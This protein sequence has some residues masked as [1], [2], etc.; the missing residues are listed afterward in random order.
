MK[1]NNP[2]NNVCVLCN[3]VFPRHLPAA[4]GVPELLPVPGPSGLHHPRRGAAAGDH[5]VQL[6]PHGAGGQ[7]DQL[8]AAVRDRETDFYDEE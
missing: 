3:V 5:S 2:K 4:H 7:S 8:S 1:S 6:P